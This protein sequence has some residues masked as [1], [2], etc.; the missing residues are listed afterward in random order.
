MISK[1][2]ILFGET[3]ENR[4]SNERTNQIVV[5]KRSQTKIGSSSYFEL[6]PII[7]SVC[8]VSIS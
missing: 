6:L 3:K 1:F 4:R 5:I 2:V 8:G 7:I